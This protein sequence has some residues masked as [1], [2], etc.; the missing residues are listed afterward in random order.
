MPLRAGRK[1]QEHPHP[2]G[3]LDPCLKQ[4]VASIESAAGADRASMCRRPS[5]FQT[6]GS[7]THNVSWASTAPA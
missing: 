7:N 6:R 4:A 5:P 3:R 2:S 1:E